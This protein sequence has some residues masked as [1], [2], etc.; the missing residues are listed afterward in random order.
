MKHAS[1][2]AHDTGWYLPPHTP[3][4]RTQFFF[5]HRPFS[6]FTHTAAVAS[7]HSKSSVGDSSTASTAT[8]TNSSVSSSG[9]VNA[10]RCD[11]SSVGSTVREEEEEQEVGGAR[12]A[13]DGPRGAAPPATRGVS[14]VTCCDS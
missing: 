11:S 3:R 12:E 1:H 5:L 8:M 2:A 9:T 7:L 14:L 6:C 13:T 4:R 10:S